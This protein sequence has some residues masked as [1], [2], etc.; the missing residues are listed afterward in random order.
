MAREI[1]RK[2]LVRRDRWRPNGERRTRYRQGYLSTDPERIV[3]VRADG[4]MAFLTI[5]GLTVGT[6]RSEY[7]YRISVDDADEMLDQLCLR[8]LIE[9]VRYREAFGEH[10]WEIDVFEGA[11]EG[12]VVAEIE[13]PSANAEF[14][15]PPWL[16]AEVSDDP[17]YFNSNLV[18]APFSTWTG[19]GNDHG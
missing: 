1:E 5:K 9:K 6:S 15:A 8:P 2:F 4:T 18:R 7:E 16:G 17:R 14:V 19:H 13:L 10:T 3:R 11:N 12:L